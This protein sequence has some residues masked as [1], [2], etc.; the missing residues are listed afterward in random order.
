MIG[1]VKN[2]QNGKIVKH[3]KKLY[4]DYEIVECAK[5]TTPDKKLMYEVEIVKD[6]KRRSLIFD[7]NNTYLREEMDEDDDDKDL[8]KTQQRQ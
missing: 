2:G 6:K 7:I 3:A 5:I 8:K 1:P 4:P